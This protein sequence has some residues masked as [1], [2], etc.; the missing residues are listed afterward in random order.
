[1]RAIHYL[2]RSMGDHVLYSPL[3][4]IFM[5][6]CGDATVIRTSVAH[7]ARAVFKDSPAMLSNRFNLVE[8]QLAE[9]ACSEMQDGRRYTLRM[10]AL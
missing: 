9:R 3:P 10:P 6:G 4:N 5:N 8:R 2:K 1:M 7:W